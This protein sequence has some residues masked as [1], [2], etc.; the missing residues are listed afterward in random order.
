M[1]GGIISG[2]MGLAGSIHN[3]NV[4]KDLGQQQIN[5]SKEIYGHQTAY[6]RQQ[7]KLM[8]AREDNAVQRRARDMQLAGINPLLAAGSPSEAKGSTG[9][10]GDMSMASSGYNQM[11]KGISEAASQLGGIVGN[12]IDAIR[13]SQELK[14]QKAQIDNIEADTANKQAQNPMYQQEIKKME[15]EIGKIQADTKLSE[16]M[17][18]NKITEN[19]KANIIETGQIKGGVNIWGTG[20]SGDRKVYQ[21]LNEISKE[22]LHNEITADTARKKAIKKLEEQNN[23]TNNQKESRQNKKSMIESSKPRLPHGMQQ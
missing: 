17:K 6:K 20:F 14:A 9:L 23:P 4:Q 22:L 18:V 5:L 11:G 21:T 8:Q 7:D 19:L 1:L 13:A 16:Q 3:A 10:G 12:S 2:A 15:A